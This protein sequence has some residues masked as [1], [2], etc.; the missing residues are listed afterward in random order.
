MGIDQNRV[1]VSSIESLCLASHRK[2]SLVAKG[3]D[4]AFLVP[5]L[6][7]NATSRRSAISADKNSAIV[8]LHHENR[9]MRTERVP[10]QTLAGQESKYCRQMRQFMTESPWIGISSDGKELLLNSHEYRLSRRP[11]WSSSH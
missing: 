10:G 6:K 7:A 8:E 2:E 9:A 3:S 1:P 5:I 4:L 11:F